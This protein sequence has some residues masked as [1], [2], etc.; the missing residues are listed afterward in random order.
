LSGASGAIVAK[1]RSMY[2]K[3]LT[4]SDYDAMIAQDSVGSVA[5]F[6][7]ANPAYSETT[8]SLGGGTV[9]R[10]VLEDAVRR[11]R[12]SEFERLLKYEITVG[13]K[14]AGYIISTVEVETILRAMYAITP[15]VDDPPGSGSFTGSA[16]I[17]GHLS[18]DV[19]EVLAARTV[20][21]IANAVGA[22]RYRRILASFP[23]QADAADFIKAEAALRAE[24]YTGAVALFEDA[25]AG[26]ACPE[27]A[28]MLGDRID[29]ENVAAAY[30]LKKFFSPTRDDVLS[31]MIP[32]GGMKAETA[33]AI[34][35]ADG[36]DGVIAAARADR[37]M[38]KLLAV[39]DRCRTV[40]EAPVR[41]VYSESCRLIRYSSS[42]AA[43][44]ASYYNVVSV[45]CGNVIKIIEGKR[46]GVPP[47]DIRKML[48]TDD[49]R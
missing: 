30:R 24:Y 41:R 45:E 23:E 49:G 16:Y 33:E 32:G 14:L 38:K 46:Y 29:L 9:G 40:D 42:S 37:E 31:S 22:S 12:F 2:G 13:G 39:L 8:R 44:T 7:S 43:V 5:R 25:K 26:T 4:E 1:I 47:D 3:R 17:D 11:A 21:E 20:K 28:G 6:L 36:A 48:I 27:I 10:R 18:F 19:P 35:T 34:A 15:G